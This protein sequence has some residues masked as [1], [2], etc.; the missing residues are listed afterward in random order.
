MYNGRLAPGGSA[1][2]TVSV[3][4]PSKAAAAVCTVAVVDNNADNSPQTI[5]VNY[6]VSE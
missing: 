1:T 6:A 3:D 5:T 2:F 4:P